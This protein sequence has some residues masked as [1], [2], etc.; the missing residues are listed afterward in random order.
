MITYLQGTIIDVD[1]R[2]IDKQLATMLVNGVG[3]GVHVTSKANIKENEE[4]SLYIHTAVREDAIELYGF[5]DKQEL[6]T[7]KL[8]INV[9]G[10]GAKTALGMLSYYDNMTLLSLANNKDAAAIAKCPGIGLK[11][12]QKIVIELAGKI[13]NN[14]IAPQNSDVSDA[15]EVLKSLGY[16]V[17][18]IQKVL[19]T[20]ETNGL[21]TNQIVTKV[22]QNM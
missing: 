11:T 21:T 19:V 10:V 20:I 18:D 2:V 3:Y 7:F 15:I 5:R 14:L 8:L 12:A 4:V 1:R 17:S 16:K 6:E 9:N 13:E 22:L